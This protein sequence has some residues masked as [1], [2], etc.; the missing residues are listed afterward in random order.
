MI[1][2]FQR[3]SG[4]TPI[5]GL[6]E[7]S[8][9]SD[10][11]WSNSETV[12]NTPITGPSWSWL[13]HPQQNVDN[14]SK[15]FERESSILEPR[16][17]SFK[18]KWSGSAFTSR[19]VSSTLR[20]SGVIR[21]FRVKNGSPR[22]DQGFHVAHPEPN[23]GF[24]AEVQCTLDD[25]SEIADGLTITCL[26][27]FYSTEH[28]ETEDY[29]GD[30]DGES[31]RWEHFLVIAPPSRASGFSPA[32]PIVVSDASDVTPS[33]S[34]SYRRLGVGNFEVE[35]IPKEEWPREREYDNTSWPNPLLMFDGA[36][37]VTI[38]LV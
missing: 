38:E 10:L 3:R 29:Y 9:V 37:R 35:L 6:W 27:L 36:K 24:D 30:L 33:P 23:K 7:S 8:F 4:G 21:T 32:E 15:W 11:S 2:Y 31:R 26:F 12:A 34:K 28:I 22:W 1:R 20:V 13:S 25:G 19:L 16:L 18:V 14:H 5:L 17:E